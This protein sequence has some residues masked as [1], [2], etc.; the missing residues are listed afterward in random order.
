MS[1]SAERQLAPIRTE[2]PGEM[3]MVGLSAEF[4]SPRGISELWQ[5]FAPHIGQIPGQIGNIAYGVVTSDG[6]NT[7]KFNYAAAV[8]VNAFANVPAQLNKLTI[9]AYK[10]EV[11]R[12]DAHAS[13]ISST[14]EKLHKMGAFTAGIPSE[15][16]FLAFLE[17]YGEQFDPKTGLGGMEVWLPSKD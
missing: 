17:Y 12:H 16:K 6:S 15:G 13:Q 7:A 1:P 8:R 11:F 4:T 3:L 14:V 10:Y 2:T 5:R 9:P